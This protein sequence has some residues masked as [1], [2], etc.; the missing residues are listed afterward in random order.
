MHIF[1]RK[2]VLFLLLPILYFIIMG[3]ANTYIKNHT[4]PDIGRSRLLIAGDSYMQK[5]INPN[6][7]DDAQSIAQTAE[8]Y[9]ITYWKLQALLPIIQPDTILLGFSHHNI[10]AFNDRKFSDPHI[11]S[12]LFERVEAIQQFSSFEP[13]DVDQWLRAKVWWKQYCFYPHQRHHNYV[14]GYENRPTSNLSDS[15]EAIERHFGSNG[16][17]EN[18]SAISI[19]YL[20]SIIN[21]CKKEQITLIFISSPV[22]ASYGRLIPYYYIDQYYQII[23]QLENVWAYSDGDFPDDYFLNSDHLNSKGAEHF[24]KELIERIRWEQT[25]KSDNCF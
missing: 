23:N 10:A 25:T 2:L 7:F 8:P 11:A 13:L 17:I 20:D 14:G 22:S 12:E 1:I 21:L 6:L 9:I 19:A 16:H 3:V 18:A 15:L 5:A 24:T 4:G